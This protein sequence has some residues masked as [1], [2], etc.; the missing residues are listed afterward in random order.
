[1]LGD[2]GLDV[3]LGVCELCNLYLLITVS[4]CGEWSWE[5][6]SKAAVKSEDSAI[7]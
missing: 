6:G 2:V 7:H 5:V 4:L 3:C 1:M